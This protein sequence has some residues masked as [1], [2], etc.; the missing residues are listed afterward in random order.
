LAIFAIA[1]IPTLPLRSFCRS[2]YTSASRP[3]VVVTEPFARQASA[4]E[5][6]RVNTTGTLKLLQSEH[7]FAML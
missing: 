6:S 4:G 3:P 2:G 5:R 7:L 1:A